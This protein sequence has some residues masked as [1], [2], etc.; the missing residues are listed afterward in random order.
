LP[1][2]V[3]AQRGDA[4]I[5]FDEAEDL[6]E[7]AMSFSKPLARGSKV[8]VNRIIEQNSVPV[9]WT[10]N[11]VS[12]IDPAVLRRMMMAIE[13]KTPN[14]PVRARIWRRVLAEAEVTL[15]EDA[16]TRLSGRYAA[17]P[18]VAASAARA[19]ALVDGGEAEIEQAMG[20]VLQILGIGPSVLDADG[21]D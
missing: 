19:A 13:I 2:R 20:G 4:L 15:E 9:L 12:D 17:P 18:A 14:Q 16:V 5:L 8:Y 21:R 10:C 1:Q 11:E 7:S 6:L 3:S